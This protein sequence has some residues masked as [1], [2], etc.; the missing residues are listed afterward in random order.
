MRFFGGFYC[1][2]LQFLRKVVASV[3]RII[4]PKTGWRGKVEDALFPDSES[5][6]PAHPT[7]FLCGALLEQLSAT[8]I[9]AATA[10][11]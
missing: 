10:A 5:I 9:D 4:S 1:A 8:L 6:I 7:C 3:N 2:G 11:K